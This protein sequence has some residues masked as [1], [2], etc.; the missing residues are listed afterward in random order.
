MLGP[1]V[2]PVQPMYQLVG[3][4]NLEL[5][6]MYHYLLQA[7]EKEYAVIHDLNGYDEISLTGSVKVYTRVTEFVLESYQFTGETYKQADLFGGSTVEEASRIFMNILENKGTRAQNDTVIANAAVAI[8]RF[9][10]LKSLEMSVLEAREA[11]I[12][13]KALSTFKS[14]M[15]S[16]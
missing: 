13:G 6:R 8:Q 10:P 9:D 1:L 7:E 15:K 3:V 14:F 11:L 12:S 4:F 5:A 2:N 16:M